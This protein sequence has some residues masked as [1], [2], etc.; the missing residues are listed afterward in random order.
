MSGIT[1]FSP[2]IQSDTVG[3]TWMTGADYGPEGSVVTAVVILIGSS[4]LSG[5]P[6]VWPIFMLSPSS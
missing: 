6:V 2:I 1:Q 4:L 5:R 3:P